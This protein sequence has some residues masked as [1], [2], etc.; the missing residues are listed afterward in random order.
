MISE[1]KLKESFSIGQ[2][3]IEGFENS[4]T[5]A[6]FV[7]INLRKKKWLL[8]C[9]YSP[10]NENIENHLETLSNNLALYSSS[11]ENLI[12]MGYFN[13]WVEEISMSGFCD[14][15]SFKSLRKD[16]TCYKN[17]ENPSSLSDFHRMVVT[18]MKTSFERLKPRVINYRD[19]KSFEKNYFEKNRYLNYQI[20]L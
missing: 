7:E 19:Y 6:F 12:I 20:H 18:A 8:S 16:A 14:A 5:E 2:F 17:L 11:Y 10:N 9:S 1:T 15:F 4:P 13:V 3:I